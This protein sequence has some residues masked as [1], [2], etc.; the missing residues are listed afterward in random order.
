MR[1]SFSHL[2]KEV[3]SKE[4]GKAKMKPMKFDW[5]Q[6]HHGFLYT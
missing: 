6:R 4:K 2:E 5:N 3:M 1:A